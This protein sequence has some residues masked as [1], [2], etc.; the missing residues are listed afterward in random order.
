MSQSWSRPFPS[1]IALLSALSLLLA[2]AQ[3][4]ISLLPS[5]PD[6]NFFLATPDAC[7]VA[8][9]PCLG[10]IYCCPLPAVC[11]PDTSSGSLQYVCADAAG[12]GSGGGPVSIPGG[13]G[14]SPTTTVPSGGFGPLMTPT[15]Q[16][17]V[18]GGNSALPTGGEVVTPLPFFPSSL[19]TSIPLPS[20]ST[21]SFSTSTPPLPSTIISGGGTADGN[22]NGPI[23][24][25]TPSTTAAIA[26]FPSSTSAVQGGPGN[27]NSGSGSASN[28]TA[29]NGNTPAAFT[30][31]AAPRS[32]TTFTA[33]GGGWMLV[34]AAGMMTVWGAVMR[35]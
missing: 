34:V 7:N 25:I 18:P 32:A 10:G 28:G 8:N 19:T 24:P 13:G 15:L 21:P 3:T 6:I 35:G 2:I 5:T 20:T 29:G 11:Y 16:P 17:V 23:S 4:Q 27:A 1:L 12:F 31:A 14:I 9:Y 33:W 26:P 30:G 22:K